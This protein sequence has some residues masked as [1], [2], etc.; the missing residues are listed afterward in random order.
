MKNILNIGLTSIPL[1]MALNKLLSA[2]TKTTRKK[3][4]KK[5]WENDDEEIF[6]GLDISLDDSIDFI[7]TSVPIWDDEDDG[8]TVLDF[9]KFY[10]FCMEVK[11]KKL[12]KTDI[13][14][15]ILKLANESGTYEWNNFYR[16]II[17]KKLQTKLP[18]KEIAETMQDIKK[19]LED[20][21]KTDVNIVLKR[22]R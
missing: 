8:T 15:K 2:K 3:I 1:P 16:L 12:S 10:E 17:L 5:L 7:V 18:I 11:F 9:N 20:N 13:D 4:I 19:E 14:D 6:L 22:N 21:K